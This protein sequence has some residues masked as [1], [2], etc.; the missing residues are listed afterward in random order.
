MIIPAGKRK[1]QISQGGDKN[2]VISDALEKW[3]EENLNKKAI[4]TDRMYGDTLNESYDDLSSVFRPQTNDV[5]QDWTPPPSARSVQPSGGQS[6]FLTP[7]NKEE[8]N[9]ETKTLMEEKAKIRSIAQGFSIDLKRTKDGAFELILMPPEGFRI[10]NPDELVMRIMESVGGEVEES[11]DPDPRGGGMRVVYR[12][13][14]GPQQM[15]KKRR[16]R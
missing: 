4:T 6:Q 3:A 12:S 1:L 2:Q 7:E 5:P 8:E 14:L 11:S 16:G 15:V 9:F 13:Q 10:P